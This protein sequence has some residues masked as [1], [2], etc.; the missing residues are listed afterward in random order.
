MVHRSPTSTL[1]ARAA[2]CTL[3]GSFVL[4]G[5]LSVPVMGRKLRVTSLQAFK[6]TSNRL[7]KPIIALSSALVIVKLLQ[8]ETDGNPANTAIIGRAS[9]IWLINGHGLPF[10]SAP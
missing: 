7:L 3:L 9:L 10:T 2:L 1:A 5:V 6:V 8:L 4:I